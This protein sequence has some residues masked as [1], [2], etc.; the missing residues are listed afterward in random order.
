MLKVENASNNMEQSQINTNDILKIN[1]NNGAS[2]EFVSEESEIF[3]GDISKNWS[4]ERR[5]F[6][7]RKLR[8]KLGYT[9]KPEAMK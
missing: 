9:D 1:N 8:K 4:D 7:I 3:Q 5:D 2:L 6:E